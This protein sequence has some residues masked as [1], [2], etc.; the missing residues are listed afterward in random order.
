VS[1]GR[2][3]L[4]RVFGVESRK[5]AE[6]V[7]G[8]P[9]FLSSRCLRCGGFGMPGSR[10]WCGAWRTGRRNACGPGRSA[11]RCASCPQRVC[12][13]SRCGWAGRAG[14]RTRRGRTLI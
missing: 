14:R 9:M 5:S 11:R 3:Q 13:R 10:S 7:G 1:G 2:Q 12:G 8:V 6:T 4:W